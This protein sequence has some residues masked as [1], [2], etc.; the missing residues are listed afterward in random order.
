MKLTSS[1]SQSGNSAPQGLA[2]LKLGMN[3]VNKSGIQENTTCLFQSF[4]PEDSEKVENPV[5]AVDHR[6]P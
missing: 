5:Q 3:H 2:D 1:Y 4:I 6:I